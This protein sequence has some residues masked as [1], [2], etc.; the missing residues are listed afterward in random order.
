[1]G[2]FALAAKRWLLR[3]IENQ[4]LAIAHECAAV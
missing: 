3:N 2:E 1:M 4:K